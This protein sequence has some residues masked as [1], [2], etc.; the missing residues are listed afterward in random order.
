M[1]DPAPLTTEERIAALEA[2]S[3]A[4]KRFDLAEKS[5]K[6]VLDADIHIDNKAGRILAAVAFLTAACTAIFAKAYNLPDPSRPRDVMDLAGLEVS[7]LSFSAF[8]LCILTGALLYL[9]ALGPAL[10]IPD[11]LKGAEHEVKSLLFFETIGDLTESSWVDHWG[12]Q[13]TN[14]VWT[15]KPDAKPEDVLS[16]EMTGNFLYEARLIAQKIQ[17]KIL[18]MG[19]GSFLFKL[20]L[21][22]LAPLVASLFTAEA[23]WGWAAFTL[24]ISILLFAFALESWGRPPH[25]AGRRAVAFLVFAILAF[26]I[27]AAKALGCW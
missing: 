14:R 15:V 5:F 18:F 1:S 24:G 8:L 13:R 12:L 2:T 26:L 21:V 10:N 3:K 27:A 19:I 9:A 7:L 11:S 17:T 4:T 16:L 25:A 22:F 20:A 6:T 23:R